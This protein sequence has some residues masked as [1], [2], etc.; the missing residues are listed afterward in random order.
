MPTANGSFTD[1]A[2]LVRTARADVTLMRSGAEQIHHAVVQL[3]GDE[4][5]R[6]PTKSHCHQNNHQ[7]RQIAEPKID[8]MIQADPVAVNVRVGIKRP[9]GLDGEAGEEIIAIKMRA[10]SQQ[11]EDENLPGPASQKRGG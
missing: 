2:M 5:Q 8:R 7:H 9:I 11:R 10:E 3:R 4:L 6:R 1:H